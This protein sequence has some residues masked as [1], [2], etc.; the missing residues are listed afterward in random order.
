MKAL[1]A[2]FLLFLTCNLSALACRGPNS[3]IA[4]EKDATTVFEGKSTAY[5]LNAQSSLAKVNFEVVKII[6]GQVGKELSV[7]MRGRKLPKSLVE[8]KK[9]FGII[10]TVG[11]RNL[12]NERYQAGLPKDFAGFPFVVDA[13]CNMN[14]DSWYLHRL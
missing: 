4:Q 9:Q 7:I 12:D 6:R 1:F 2:F 8:F 14:G 13:A 10:S 11:I 3:E 5:E